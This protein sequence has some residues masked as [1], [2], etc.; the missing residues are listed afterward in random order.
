MTLSKDRLTKLLHKSGWTGEELGQLIM[1]SLISDIKQKEK[2]E[3]K[4]L[5]T[6]TELDLMVS[7]L[8]TSE[9]MTTYG[10]YCDLY[11]EIVDGYNKGQGFIQQFENGFLNALIRYKDISTEQNELDYKKDSPIIMT[12]KQYKE[13][14]EK[15]LKLKE[16][17]K[18]SF[19]TLIFSTLYDFMHDS[20][21]APKDIQKALD[22]T[23]KKLVKNTAFLKLYNDVE[24]RGHY[25]PLAGT[26][27]NEEDFN[28]KDKKNVKN[29]GVS[30]GISED[31]EEESTLLKAAKFFIRG[32]EYLETYVKEKT[33]EEIELTEEEM[34]IIF[35]KLDTINTAENN[36]KFKLITKALEI[37]KKGIWRIDEDLPKGLKAYDLLDCIIDSADYEETDPKKHLAAFKKEYKEL[38]EAISGYIKEQIPQLKAIK[39]TQ[40]YKE[41]ITWK[42]LADIG[43]L[44]YKEQLPPSDREIVEAWTENSFITQIRVFFSGIA[45]LRKPVKATQLD[46]KGYYVEPE[47]ERTYT[48]LYSIEKNPEI[49]ENMQY[50]MRGLVISALSYFYAYNTYL[51]IISK[52]YNIPDIDEIAAI[53]TSSYERR[54][55]NLNYLLCDLYVTIK[56]DTP[57]E[58]AKKRTLIT[59]IFTFIELEDLKPTQE[60]IKKL[61][62]KLKRLGFTKGARKQLKD[63]TPFIEMLANST[64][65]G[66]IW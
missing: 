39:A 52:V 66:G 26:S 58:T 35:D 16:P 30:L 55:N 61:E 50:Q 65:G 1:M 17:I 27:Q 43:F 59:K 15:A 48:K 38:Y 31:V 40:L 56:G 18:E 51:E 10:V 64:K 25:E 2:K 21:K 32:K 47:I 33:G 29:T 63:V 46:K 8:D 49:I 4:P 13:L 14:K 60:A 54:I 37:K 45:I 7:T 19:Y 57:Q 23:K 9:E 6:Q 28:A 36:Q 42:E 3:K 22:D 20:Q 44:D 53:D 11:S 12:E 24:G 62:R 41:A 34:S 5:F